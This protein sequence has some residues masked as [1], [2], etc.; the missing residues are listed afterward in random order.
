M[1]FENSVYFKDLK[2]LKIEMP[3]GNFYLCK[4][5]FVS[6]MHE[7][8][9]F[10]WELIQKIMVKVVDF[11]GTNAKVGYISNRINSYSSDPKTW[12]LVD[13]EFGI[14]VGGAIVVYNQMAFMNATLEKRFY[15]KSIKRCISL[16]EA[17]GWINNLQELN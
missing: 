4:K 11:Y 3:F 13:K 12:D 6:E 2:P 17:V 9:H 8:V 7:G 14:I 16:D 1:K 15:E 10:D 5:F